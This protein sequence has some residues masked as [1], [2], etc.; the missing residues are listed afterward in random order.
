MIPG[1]GK[2]T[3]ILGAAPDADVVVQAP[4][5]APHHARLIKQ[6]GQIFFEG[7]NAAPSAANGAP[8]A[9]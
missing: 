1:L 3:L 6:N 7:G 8:I 4:G 9:P 5:V 2:E